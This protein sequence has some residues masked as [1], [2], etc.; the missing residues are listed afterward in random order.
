MNHLRYA[1]IERINKIKLEEEDF[2]SNYWENNFCSFTDIFSV[3]IK[4]ITKHISEITFEDLN[5]DDLLRLLEYT[6]LCRNDISRNR[7]TELLRT[8]FLDKQQI[9]EE[10]FNKKYPNKFFWID[11]KLSKIWDEINEDFLIKYDKEISNGEFAGKQQIKFLEYLKEQY[12][13][14]L[15][16][17]INL[18]ELQKD[19]IKFLENCYSDLISF[20]ST[21]NYKESQ[22]IIDKGEELRKKIKNFFVE[23]ACDLCNKPDKLTYYMCDRHHNDYK[24]WKYEKDVESLKP[25]DTTEY[26]EGDKLIW[27]SGVGYDVGYFVS[28][29]EMF[30]VSCIRFKFA[31][32]FSSGREGNISMSAIFP[33]SEEKIIKMTDKYGMKKDFEQ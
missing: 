3:E 16:H 4:V 15:P 22:E 25:I 31:S 6:I 1:L 11:I 29:S 33:Y 2:K 17:K 9:T 7:V 5:D 19:Y 13:V 21:H 14:I 18:I 8:P 26:E 12:P 30:D 27:D 10:K 28:Y 20:V 32:G 23:P 24:R